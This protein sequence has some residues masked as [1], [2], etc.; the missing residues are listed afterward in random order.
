MSSVDPWEKAAEC[1]R[2]LKIVTDPQRRTILANLQDLWIA[3]ANESSVRL[4]LSGTASL[5]MNITR[6]AG[7]LGAQYSNQQRPSP[8]IKSPSGKF[9]FMA[10]HLRQVA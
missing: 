8:L 9:G 1:A 4:S 2:A 5:A 10:R 3:L 6:H 7:D